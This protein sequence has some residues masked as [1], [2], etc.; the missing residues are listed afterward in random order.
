MGK[1][2][3]EKAEVKQKQ[4]PEKIIYK[5]V[6]DEHEQASLTTRQIITILETINQIIDYLKQKEEK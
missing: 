5:P 6:A 3:K 2:T 4:L 1:L